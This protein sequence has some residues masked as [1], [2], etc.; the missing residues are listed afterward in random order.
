MRLQPCC[1]SYRAL[2]WPALTRSQLRL[3]PP[4]LV[5]CPRPVPSRSFSSSSS[6]PHSRHHHAAH[7][8]C[9]VVQSEKAAVPVK[10]WN[11]GVTIDPA[12][13]SQLLN[14]AQLPI[15]HGH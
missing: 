7:S 13:I 2:L 14:V 4:P 12:T 11:H 8:L 3:Q 10:V 15:V 5:P 6:S 1:G 9:S